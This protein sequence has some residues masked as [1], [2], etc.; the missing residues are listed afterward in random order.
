M[1]KT[2]DAPNG[3]MDFLFASMIQHF[4]QEG[5][6]TVNLGMV[7]LSGIDEPDN[8]P[9]RA[10]K[11]AYEKMKQFGHYK[12][13]RSFKDKFDPVWSKV[14]VAYDSDL[15]LVN[16]TTILNKVMKVDTDTI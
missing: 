9:E 8:L 7:P 4:K 13:L 14:Y 5:F 12:S 3:T 6:T 2:A 11:L 16:L 1:R 10:M 15:D